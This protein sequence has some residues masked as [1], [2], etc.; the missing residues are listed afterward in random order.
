MY[1]ICITGEKMYC[2]GSTTLYGLTSQLSLLFLVLLSVCFAL[3][4]YF[5]PPPPSHPS[6]PPSIPLLAQRATCLY[7]RWQQEQ[8][9][10]DKP[11]TDFHCHCTTAP[12]KKQHT[13]SHTPHTS[14][15]TTFLLFLSWCC[16]R[17][18]PISLS[19][20]RLAAERF[21]G[22]PQKHC[23]DSGSFHYL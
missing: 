8:M 21:S 16:G 15:R 12:H 5:P 20:N 18:P 7:F 10:A 3:Y 1:P 11:A 9:L 22:Q 6:L 2:L 19:N 23:S 14:Y 13:H 4:P 17:F